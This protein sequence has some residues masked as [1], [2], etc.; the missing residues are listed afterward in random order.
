MKTLISK[1]FGV[2]SDDPLEAALMDWKAKV[3]FTSASIIEPLVRASIK[4]HGAY[5]KPY[6]DAGSITPHHLIIQFVA[7]AAGDE[8][9]SG[10][11]HFYRGKLTD[12]GRRLFGNYANA[13]KEIAALGTVVNPDGSI[14]TAEKADE[15]IK[16]MWEIVRM[17]G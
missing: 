4:Q 9:E 3:D 13:W 6:L 16:Q 5:F 14:I 11:Y 10:R 2:T 8:I 17:S 1:L 7:N 12:E 15:E